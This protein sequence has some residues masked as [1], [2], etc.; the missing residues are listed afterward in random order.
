VEAGVTATM[1]REAAVDA[2]AASRL[3]LHPEALDDL[4][5]SG[6]S[7]AAIAEAGLYTAAPGD[8]PRLLGPRLAERVRHALVFPYDGGGPGGAWRRDGE[9]VRC[10]LFPPVSDADGHTIRYYQGGGTPARLY[11]P[12]RARAALADPH[13]P[14][15]ITEGEKKALKANQEGLLCLGL[16]GLWNWRH[17][18]RPIGDLDRIDWFGREAILVPDGDVWTRAD[19]LQPVYA[20]GKELESRGAIVGVLK[21]PAGASGAPG[22]SPPGSAPPSPGSAP[23]SKIGLDDY[24]R[25]HPREALDDLPRIRLRHSLFSR[26][27]D[28]WKVWRTQK[29]EPPAA[30]REPSVLELLQRPQNVRVLHPAQEVLDGELWYGVAAEPLPRAERALIMVSSGRQAY[31]ADR[32]PDDI[33][34]RHTD[35]GPSTVSREAAVRWL[36]GTETG[37]VAKALDGLAD[38]FL[39]YVVLR[40]RR[41]ALWVAAWALG[42]WSYRAFRVFPYLSIRSAEKRCGKS[43]LLSLLQRVCFNASPVTAHPTEAQLYRSAARTGGAQVFDEIETL[44]GDRER[45]DALITVLNVGFERGGVVTRL[46]KRGDRFVEE[47]YEAYA[48]R[49]LAG[50]AGLKDTLDDR[51][52]SVVMLRRRASEKVARIGRATDAEA[53]GLRDQCALAS[54]TRI[55]DLLAA[56]EMAPPALEREGIDDRAVDLWSPLLAIAYVADSEDTGDRSR[57]IIEAA[58]ALAAVRDADAE[59]GTAARL[60]EALHAIRERKGESV[61]P[62]DLLEALRARPGWDWVKSTRRL[63]GLLGPLGIVRQQVREG[64][65]RRWSYVLVDHQLADLRARYGGPTDAADE[66]TANASAAE[67]DP[68]TSGDNR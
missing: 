38:F 34:L 63:A 37:S 23:P 24:L 26:T 15:L 41:T 9:F 20:L 5:K 16:G 49:V 68:V 57:D 12:A 2:S 7:D 61:A 36:G 3:S 25:A 40:D 44:R 27:A 53:Q 50:I 42:T 18:G 60:V 47:P 19:L 10:K 4:R 11:I 45:F 51:A 39:R 21:L 14:L 29:A 64:G 8:L 67:P 22:E 33:A 55:G 62:A 66:P 65:R 48:P 43:R 17:G 6:L 1:D 56:Y 13:V 52:L 35:P 28:W 58:K 54:L 31:L 46:E 30:A 32:L 59:T